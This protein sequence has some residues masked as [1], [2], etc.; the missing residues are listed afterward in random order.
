[1]REEAATPTSDLPAP[2]GNTMMPATAHCFAFLL[3]SLR[4]AA[5]VGNGIETLKV[6]GFAELKLDEVRRV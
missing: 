2:H 4:H 6:R 5:A 3:L 1:M